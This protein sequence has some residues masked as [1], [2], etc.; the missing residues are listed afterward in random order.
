MS[1]SIP[2]VPPT[3]APALALHGLARTY[4]DGAAAVHALAGL[5]LTFH[6]GTFTAVMGPSGSGKTT[7]LTCAAGLERP[8]AGRVLVDG[9]DVT[10]WADDERTRF[11]RDHLGFVFQ[12]FQLM[13]YLTAEQNVALPVR[14]SGRRPDRDRVQALLARVGL[15]DRAGHL[16]AQLSGGQQ[17][18][19]ALARALVTEPSVVLADEPTGALDSRSARG[20]LELLR[21]IV[22]RPVS[23]RAQTVVMVTH[24]PV[25][26][27]YADSVAFL[28]DGRVAGQMASPS[29]DAVAGQLA[30]L[31]QLVAASRQGA[32]S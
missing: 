23:G 1:L 6:R 24:D 22:D 12:S 5:D 32:A 10:E 28:V 8:T 20:V 25:A 30:H 14:L 13:P 29:A 19:V 21:S 16:P 15:A 17:Q 26:A 18:R 3:Q 2:S 4:G 7:L 9:T 27:A 11:R 31:D